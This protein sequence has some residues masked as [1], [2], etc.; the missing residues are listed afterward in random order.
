M[1]RRDFEG[2]NDP[3]AAFWAMLT[4]LAL[5]IVAISLNWL[6]FYPVWSFLIGMFSAIFILLLEGAIRGRWWIMEPAVAEILSHPDLTYRL[7]VFVGIV[8]LIFETL[9]LTLFLTHPVLDK[10][11]ASFVLE[12]QCVFAND[13]YFARFC[14]KGNEPEATKIDPI[15]YAMRE[16]AARRFFPDGGFITCA[17]KPLAQEMKTETCL[18]AALI[19]CDRWNVSRVA[20]RPIQTGSITGTALAMLAKNDDGTYRVTV[21]SDVG[22]AIDDGSSE[23]FNLFWPKVRERI[24]QLDEGVERELKSETYRR[25]LELLSDR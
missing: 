12:R 19:R 21:W 15:D 23:S 6:G 24:Q 16:E 20:G 17:S 25:A 14:I 9:L 1:S 11:I 2:R 10:G 3:R 13:S 7:L 8:L 4:I 5:P 22:S 18:H